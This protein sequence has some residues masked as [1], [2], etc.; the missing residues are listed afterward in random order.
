VLE[1]QGD[2]DDGRAQLDS[3]VRD[4]EMR[5]QGVDDI[6]CPEFWGGL[7]IVPERVEF[8]QGRKNRLHDRFVYNRS[9][10]EDKWTLERLSP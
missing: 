6:P 2:G 1:A 7:R 5:F 10:T 3:W 4:T 9:A 8:W